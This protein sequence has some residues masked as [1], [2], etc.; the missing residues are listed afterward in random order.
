MKKIT[1]ILSFT[2]LVLHISAYS[3]TVSTFTGG[4]PDDAIVLDENGNIY[5]SNYVGD[6]VF[7]FT[8]TGDV[9]SFIT[10]LNTPN[11]LAFNS[12]QEL[13]VCDG[14]G[15]FVYKYDLNGNLLASYP[16]PGHPS[17]IIKAHDSEAMIFTEYLG[18]AINVL[19]PDGT[20]TEISSDSELVGPVGLTYD[21]ENNLYVGN[22]TDRKIYKV[23]S[24]G[25]LDY[26]ATVGN[27]SVLGFITF[28]Q[29]ML[30]TTVFGEHKIYKVNPNAVDDYT[31]FAGSTAGSMDGD[32]SQA[33]FNQP[34]GIAFNE[35]GDTM[36][37]TDFT[38]K[39]LRIIT[40]ISVLGNIDSS[41]HK[42]KFI[43][44]PNPTSNTLNIEIKNHTNNNL[45]LEIY[46]V[47]GKSTSEVD[48]SISAPYSR[49]TLDVSTLTAGIYFVKITTSEYTEVKR[50]VK[51]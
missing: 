28:S 4:T 26:I 1:T 36:Y 29:G 34:N 12:N 17:G 15:N 16:N 46:D 6:T 22:Y 24:N 27:S 8:P 20:I 32:I 48:I 25:T 41:E 37:I 45:S 19:A 47:V 31:I 14:E 39:N 10:G 38:T 7:K 23:L 18:N 50:F 2:I 33:T 44:H 3:Q 5:C 51:N 11:G 21:D 43:L 35:A 9:S 30:W 40:G 13:H 42:S 49:H